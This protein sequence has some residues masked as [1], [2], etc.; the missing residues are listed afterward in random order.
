MAVRPKHVAVNLNKI[1]K[2]IEIELRYTETPQPDL[3]HA[4]GCKDPSSA[5]Q[6]VNLVSF[7]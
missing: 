1:V 3:I 5:C 2:T 7:S 6:L 4:T